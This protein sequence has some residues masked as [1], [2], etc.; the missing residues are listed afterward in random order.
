[1]S[2][3]WV[4][5]DYAEV[6]RMEE[7]E[8]GWPSALSALTHSPLSDPRRLYQ[9]SQCLDSACSRGGAVG[10]V[11]LGVGLGHRERR[12][13]RQRVQQWNTAGRSPPSSLRRAQATME[14]SLLIWAVCHGSLGGLAPTAGK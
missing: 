1:M 12:D 5:N 4:R 9:K 10:I 7:S 14:Q 3:R 6:E 13:G 11:L 2:G 8:G